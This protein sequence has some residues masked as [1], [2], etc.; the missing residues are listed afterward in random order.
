M[1]S[2]IA[3]VMR[4]GIDEKGI[5][6]LIGLADHVS[7]MNKVAFGLLLDEEEGGGAP[8]LPYPEESEIEPSVREMLSEVEEMESDRLG[9]PGVPAYWR[10]LARNRHYFESTW[11]KHRLMLDGGV[12]D[13][14]AKAAV[15]LGV[16]ATNGSRYFIRY[17]HAALVNI[18]WE[19]GRI[20]EIFGVVDHYNS[21]NVLA[22]GMQ[23]ESDIK[24]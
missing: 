7:G 12:L 19:P 21:F 18:G 16:S 10:F 23:I 1:D 11:K 9:R 8:L 2:H 13:P 24:P 17:F 3:A 4:M 6:E 14:E 20:L 15:D 22:T 5:T